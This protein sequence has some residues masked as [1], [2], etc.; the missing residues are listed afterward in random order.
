[1]CLETIEC[2][3]LSSSL[4]DRTRPAEGW[5]RTPGEGGETA[6]AAAPGGL[7]CI[8][9]KLTAGGNPTEDLGVSR[10]GTTS[11]T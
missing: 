4:P 8:W 5:V 9:D 2:S 1:M 10:M 3:R 6:G 7:G 11:G